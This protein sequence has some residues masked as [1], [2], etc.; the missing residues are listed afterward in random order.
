MQIYR[1]VDGEE[2]G[3]KHQALPTTLVVELGYQLALAV[4]LLHANGIVHR[5]IRPTN[6]VLEDGHAR[7][8]LIDFGL[9][10]MSTSEMHT[11][12]AHEFGAPEV[13]IPEPK[14]SPAADVFSLAA[15]L[16]W[17]CSPKD[18]LTK[19][20]NDALWPCNSV[21]PDKRPDAAGVARI[22]GDLRQEMEVERQK[23]NARARLTEALSAND[24]DKQWFRRVYD[25]FE[26]IFVAIALGLHGDVLDRAS[27][28]ADFINQTLE[29]YP[30]D[31]RYGR[32]LSLGQ[33][34]GTRS[35]DG[36]KI[37]KNDFELMWA[38]RT[39]RSH[40]SNKWP[41]SNIMRRF[42]NPTPQRVRDMALHVA[43]ATSQIIGVTSVLELAELVVE[44]P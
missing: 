4:Q 5:D 43:R 14:W 37:S 32:Q 29:A 16:C 38:L 30:S 31:S 39:M 9:A 6:I 13:Q 2:L 27:H 25:R 12:V 15:T 35:H 3:T 23:A 8:V 44:G 17:L 33:L 41:R 21:E 19:R 26:P 1:W 20:V 24:R 36:V 34:K 10:R 42:D 7:P 11:Q 40:G 22:L 28:A 18:E